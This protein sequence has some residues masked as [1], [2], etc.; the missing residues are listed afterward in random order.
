M[1]DKKEAD[2]VPVLLFN[3]KGG[4]MTLF[5]TFGFGST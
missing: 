3:K 2:P 1:V 4:L 5:E